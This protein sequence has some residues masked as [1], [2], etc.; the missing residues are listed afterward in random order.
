MNWQLYFGRLAL[1]V[2]SAV[3]TVGVAKPADA[4][5]QETSGRL[6]TTDWLAEHRADEA[7]VIIDARPTSEYLS[8]HLPNAVSASFD[9][10]LATSNG[11]SVSYGGGF[12]LFAD[13]KGPLV[14]QDG[15]TKK[16]ETALRKLGVRADSKIVIYDAGAHFHA[17][18]FFFTLES[19]GFNNARVLDGGLKKWS[20]EGREKTTAIPKPPAGDVVLSEPRAALIASTDDVLHALADPSSHVITSL[21]PEWHYGV[22][23]AYSRP[24]HIPHAKLVPML[25]FFNPN[26]TWRSKAQLAAL[27]EVSG[28][29]P[30][31]PLITY[32]GG[33]PL[34]ACSYFT[35][36]HVLGRADVRMYEGALLAW[37][38]DKRDLAVHTYQNPELLRDSDWI[39]WWAG[40]R[41]QR[42]L[43]DPPAVV[44]DVRSAAAFADG[45]IPWSVNVPMDNVT[46]N[47]LDYWAGALG[48]HGVSNTTEVVLCDKGLTPTAAAGFWLL[49][50]MGH[51]QVSF[52]A[53]G[54]AGWGGRYDLSKKDTLIAAPRHP[55]FDVAIHPATFTPVEQPRKRLATPD[56]A[57]VH[58]AFPRVWVV[59]S[60]KVPADLPVGEFVHLPWSTAVFDDQGAL[61]SA[62]TLWQTFD[63]AGASYF[64]EVVC[65]GETV[66]DA[67]MCYAALRLL[68]YPTVR[69]YVP[70]KAAL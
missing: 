59:S 31:E 56:G 5:T 11:R 38:A 45:H 44:V 48:A 70:A 29:G 23:L 54:I 66:G 7:L 14:F 60:D 46:S 24:G 20:A 39:Q 12:D 58:P 8:G 35:F 43:M 61:K 37:L 9:E 69:I 16:I 52:C 53:D 2:F 28:I 30:G 62:G 64:D 26:G 65:A 19:R 57:T 6:V 25:Y 33:N 55:R 34:S 67:A 13:N 4:F 49:E 32:C 27:L 50:Y 17:A 47:S 21:T 68:G 15:A 3:I 18:R 22:D 51:K 10:S 41:I 42:L 40:E 1:L 63:K 36:K